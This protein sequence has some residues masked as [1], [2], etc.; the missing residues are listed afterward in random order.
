MALV[1]A[2]AASLASGSSVERARAGFY[3]DQVE[4]DRAIKAGDIFW[5]EDPE[6]H[7]LGRN[8]GTL[9]ETFPAR[10]PT[11]AAYTRY[12]ECGSIHILRPRVRSYQRWQFCTLVVHEYGHTINYE[13][14]DDPRNIMYHKPVTAGLHPKVC[15]YPDPHRWP[16]QGPPKFR[17]TSWR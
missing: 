14:V 8:G 5:Q 7:C 1:A 15:D 6:N 3:P 9:D 4:M 10:H 11:A 2:T 13:H 17:Q 16:A 12:G